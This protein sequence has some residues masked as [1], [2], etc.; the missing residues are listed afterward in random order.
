MRTTTVA[1]IYKHKYYKLNMHSHSSHEQTCTT[2]ITK[3][4]KKKIKFLE[5][6]SYSQSVVPFFHLAVL[7][8]TWGSRTAK[9]F[10]ALLLRLCSTVRGSNRGV[11]GKMSTEWNCEPQKAR[12]EYHCTLCTEDEFHQ[13]SPNDKRTEIPG[14]KTNKQNTNRFATSMAGE[15]VAGWINLVMNFVTW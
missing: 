12:H 7:Y 14:R 4:Q 8:E 6:H 15:A 13:Q 9:H 10:I 1:N 3:K 5:P 11:T 2:G